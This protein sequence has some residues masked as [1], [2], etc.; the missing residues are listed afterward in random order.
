LY[1][2]DLNRVRM[3]SGG[4]IGTAAGN[5]SVG[6]Q[7]DGGVATAARISG[8]SGVAAASGNLYIADSGNNRVRMVANGVITTVAGNGN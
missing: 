3:V 7:G 8:A 4:V 2:A 6:Y 1:I 5:G